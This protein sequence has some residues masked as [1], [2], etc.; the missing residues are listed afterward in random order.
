MSM[1]DL[2][3]VL[4]KDVVKREFGKCGERWVRGKVVERGMRILKGH[5]VKVYEM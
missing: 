1:S 3:G 4:G 2:S 5:V